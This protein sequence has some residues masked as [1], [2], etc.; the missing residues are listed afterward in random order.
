[1]LDD[2]Y[3]LVKKEI[4]GKDQRVDS[5][6]SAEDPILVDLYSKALA[7]KVSKLRKSYVEA[8][9]LCE[10]DLAKISEIL[11]IPIE[12]L[13]VYHEFFFDVKDLDK[14]GRIEHIES[15]KDE[16]ER[17][18]KLWS[19]GQK[20][21][22]I[23]WRLGDKVSLSPVEGLVEM[24]STCMYKA[25]ESV[26]SNNSSD[27]SKEAIKWTKMSADI[28]RLLKLWTMDNAAAKTDLE[29]AIKEVVP[30]FIGID[31]LLED[32]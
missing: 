4:K 30:D 9:L 10:P 8:S 1:M 22:F 15:V 31:S 18:L 13:E 20:M 23:A 12:I 32:K 7:I 2:K 16:N 25:K 17:Q 24:F 27:S 5:I 11:E 21:S 14:L 26:Y 19:L 29:L 3:V 6:L 28:A